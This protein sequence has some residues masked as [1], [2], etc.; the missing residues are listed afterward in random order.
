MSYLLAGSSDPGGIVGVAANKN[1][2]FDV[3]G[4][5][6]AHYPG[7]STPAVGWDMNTGAIITPT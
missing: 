1:N 7:R 6:G 5:Y 3:S 4:A 2:Y